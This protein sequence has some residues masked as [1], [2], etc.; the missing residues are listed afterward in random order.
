M[1]RSVI[2]VA[3]GK[4]SRMGSETPKQ[5]LLLKGKPVLMH[6]IEVF[7][8]FDKNMKII[9]LLPVDQMTYWKQLCVEY[10]FAI[11][12]QTAEGGATRFHSVRNGLALLDDEGLIGVHD[13]VRPLV[14]PDVIEACYRAAEWK[15]AI[16]PV[17]D[18]VETVR[19]VEGED[20]SK[21][22]PRDQYKLVQTPQVFAAGLL[23]KAYEQSYSPAFTD[24][25]S[26]VEASGHPVYMVKGN[27]EN[28]KL[29]TPFDLKVAESLL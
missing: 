15:Q 5:F 10:D 29:T 14:S 25:A 18:I 23:K 2:I 28:I 27:R 9:V 24:D 7:H 4:G 21:T 6:T 22:V 12:H 20:Q 11:P 1:K 19:L 8:A 16:I 26:V 3:G 17:T 13:G